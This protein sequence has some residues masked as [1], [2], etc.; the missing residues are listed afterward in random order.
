MAQVYEAKTNGNFGMAGFR[1]CFYGFLCLVPIADDG[2][3]LSGPVVPFPW[4]SF[5]FFG[6]SQG[7]AKA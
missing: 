5:S 1:L 3:W 2:R 6:F 7:E 4:N